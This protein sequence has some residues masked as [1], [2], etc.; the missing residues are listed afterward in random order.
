MPRHPIRVVLAD[1]HGIVLH[2]LERLFQAQTDCEV[3]A[4][5]QSGA[6]AVDAVRRM[7]VD[8]LVLDLRMPGVS[9]LDVLR[10]VAAEGLRCRPVLL[11]AAVADA[12][13]VEAIRLGAMGLVLKESS[14]GVL[15]ECVRRVHRGEQ[16]IDEQTTSGAFGRV[17]RRE[18]AE[19]EVAET[20][21]PRELDIVRMIARGHRNK[22]MASQLSITEGT[23]KIHLHNIY[24]KLGVDGRLELAVWAQER[25]LV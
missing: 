3:V 2:G 8:V 9:G 14:P 18:A 7:A 19:R 22:A 4:S 12:D 23:V 25:G 15:L 11:T 13:A 17:L 20:L 6:E 21:T 5:C 1:D 24:Q 10:A 16:W